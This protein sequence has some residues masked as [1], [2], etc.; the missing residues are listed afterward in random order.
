MEDPEDDPSFIDEDEGDGDFPEF[1]SN[2]SD[3]S[4]RWDTEIIKGV[5]WPIDM[6]T[7]GAVVKGWVKGSRNEIQC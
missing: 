7:A 3:V 1:A 2:S 4:K 6:I 5:T